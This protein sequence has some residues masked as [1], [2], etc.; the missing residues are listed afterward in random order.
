MRIAKDLREHGRAEVAMGTPANLEALQALGV[1]CDAGPTDI[2]IA[3]EGA[4]ELLDGV[5]RE[6]SAPPAASRSRPR[7]RRARCAA[8]TRTSR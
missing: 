4:E 1:S 2:V 6:L 5:E 7:T 8:S 3:I